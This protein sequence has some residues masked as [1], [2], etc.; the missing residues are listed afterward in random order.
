MAFNN[1][2]PKTNGEEQFFTS[3]KDHIHTI[4]DIGCR[5]DSE[6]ISFNGEVHYFDPVSEFIENLSHQPNENRVSHFNRFGL[7]NETTQTYYYLN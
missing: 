1:C 5:Q 2:D 7:G 3:I 4:F 6:F